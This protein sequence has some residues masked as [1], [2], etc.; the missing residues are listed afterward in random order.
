MNKN[1]ETRQMDK[2]TK[3]ENKKKQGNKKTRKREWNGGCE[4]KIGRK[5]DTEK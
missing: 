1:T 2:E 5:G 3:Q 4:K